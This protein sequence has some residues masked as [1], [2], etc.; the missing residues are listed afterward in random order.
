MFAGKKIVVG[1]TGGIAAYKAAY[2]VREIK[3][4]GAE[5]WL[6]M[7]EAA[8]RIVGPLPVESL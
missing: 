6:G 8:T 7:T 4:N 5:V 2:L 1:V 3:K